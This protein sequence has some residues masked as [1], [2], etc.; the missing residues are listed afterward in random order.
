MLCDRVGSRSGHC[1]LVWGNPLKQNTLFLIAGLLAGMAVALAG[2]WAL[3]WRPA[4]WFLP[5]LILAA[6]GAAAALFAARRADGRTAVEPQGGAHSPQPARHEREALALS[7]LAEVDRAILSHA[8]LERVIDLLLDAA[9]RAIGCNVAAI[10]LI[11]W[12]EKT[13]L[14]TF[15]PAAGNGGG[16]E[17][18]H[19]ACDDSVLAG[20]AREPQGQLLEARSVPSFLKPVA[21][22]GAGQLLIMPVFQDAKLAAVICAGL[23]AGAAPDATARAL[24][25]D[26]ADHL[27][28]ALT[29]AA[30]E[31]DLYHEANYDPVTSLPNQRLLRERLAQEISRALRESR[32]FALMY[33]DLDQFR[34]VNDGAGHRAGDLVLEQAARRIRRCT[35]EEDVVARFSGDEFVVLLPALP[36]SMSAAH[37]A[38]KLVAI[39]ADPFVIDGEEHY[40]GASV[41]I[42]VFPQDGRTPDKL[43]RNANLAMYRAKA[44]GRGQSAFF[45]ERMNADATQRAGLERDLRA[46]LAAGQLTLAY[47]PQIDL[48]TGRIIGAE[49]LVRWHHPVRGLIPPNVFV[50]V[51]EESRLIETLGR[52]VRERACAQFR[53]WQNRGLPLAR[54]AVNVSSREVRRGFVEH[55][56]TLLETQEIRPHSLEL[57]ITETLLLHASAEVMTALQL[58]HDRGVRLAIDDFGTGYSSL[59]YLKNLPFHILKIDRSFVKDLG[60]GDGS[61]GVVRAILGV[62]RS[63][64]KEVVAEGVETEEQRSFLTGEGCEAGQG[65]LWSKP[66]PAEEFEK[67]VRNWVALPQ[68][69]VA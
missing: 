15:L 14:K 16:R 36:K 7:V 61:E 68:R 47:Q 64:G 6:A 8:R 69:L 26:F 22:R 58:L 4:Q 24:A 11:G 57:E 35:R 60:S 1:G 45:D 56:R 66:L 53:T 3:G 19:A 18:L 46:A 49:A 27:G 29:A 10:T 31:R 54:I 44:A 55:I 39:L 41:G 67:L 2:M 21:L 38:E 51:A 34:K 12:E 20:L 37:V 23:G 28:V 25:R 62:A 5:A 9:P 43:L 63:L 50:E 65:Y 42:S 33:A 40:L 17:S 13:Q 32:E 52:F 59:A 48:E 30:R